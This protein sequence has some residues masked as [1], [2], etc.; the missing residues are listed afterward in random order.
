M[1]LWHGSEVIVEKP[2]LDKCRRFNDYG[3]GFYCTPY[4]EMAMEWACRTEK[5]GIANCYEL[6]MEGLSILNLESAEYSILNWLAVLA[7]NREFNVSTP[8]A[9][10]GLS[11]LLDNWLV[12][13]KP[14]DV[15]C[16]YRA[17]DSYFS[18]ARQFVNGALSL[19]QLQ[20]AM[21][22]GN[23]GVQYALIS[24]RAFAA[25]RFVE[26]KHA[27]GS[28]YYAKRFK[29][30]RAARERYLDIANGFDAEGIYIQD[31]I[32]GRVEHDDPR[33]GGLWTK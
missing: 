33:V 15:V 21:H 28:E 22:L 27:P 12:D 8:L 11:Y 32:A 4:E 2:L 9:R 7:S 10:Q 25:V 24:E 14:Y 29:R 6:A 26:W 16:G 5:G 13:L 18:F 19:Q 20:Q 1:E 30:E 31:L 23:L 3:R 17:D